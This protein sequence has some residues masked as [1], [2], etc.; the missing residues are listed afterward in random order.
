[1]F[2]QF[3][4]SKWLGVVLGVSAAAVIAGCSTRAE[5]PEKVF[6]T[7]VRTAEVISM[8]EALPI[9]SSGR[10][11]P[12]T[13][14]Q[15]AFK[16]GGVIGH[17]HVDEGD[18]VTKGDK[19]AQLDLSEIDA[20]VTL[21]EA[22]FE[23]A[24]RDFAR[25]EALYADSIVSLEQLQNV[26]TVLTAAGSEVRM[27]R[28]NRRHS[29]IFA[30]SDGRIQRRYADPNELVGG[31]QAILQFGAADNWVVR[32]G[33]PDRD[34]VRLRLGD[35]ARV[36]FDAYP[37]QTF[38]GRV[39][40]IAEAADASSGTFEVEVSVMERPAL[41][42]SGF[43]AS[44]DLLPRGNQPVKLIPIEALV[45]GD[46]RTSTVFTV[47]AETGLALKLRVEVVGVYD[48][49]IAVARGLEGVEIVVTDGA[50]YLR[51]GTPVT[52][53]QTEA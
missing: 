43:I 28:F 31:G 46:G 52:I 1:M 33:V 6:V 3:L 26:E 18:R 11:S 42:K 4:S 35:D 17:V 13:S 37:G 7:A 8:E 40:E 12:K 32:L 23:K 39:T 49:W 2:M 41:L 48:D 45:E 36:H 44:V 20:Q 10:L 16:T 25:M 24:E 19:L 9:R 34:V 50:P 29:E 53:V 5:T 21:A 47:D 14:M 51:D 38:A 27:A 30:P 15:L 22:A